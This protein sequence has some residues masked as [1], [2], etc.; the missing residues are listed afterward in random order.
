MAKPVW[1]Q[2]KPPKITGITPPCHFLIKSMDFK[3]SINID[4]FNNLNY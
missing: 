1:S 3:D 2:L 4:G